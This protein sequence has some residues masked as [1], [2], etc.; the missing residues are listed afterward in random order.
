MA[1]ALVSLLSGTPVARGVAMTGEISL[2][3]HILPIGGLREKLLAAARAPHITTVLVPEGNLR[4]IHG[5]PRHL[6]ERLRIV[7]V[8]TL[9]DL[10]AVAVPGAFPGATARPRRVKG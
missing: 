5:L 10:L 3:G 2:R 6:R 9:E 8:R 4:E 1:V 7:G